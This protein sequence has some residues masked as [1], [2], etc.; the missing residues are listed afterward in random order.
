M[1]IHAPLFGRWAS[2]RTNSFHSSPHS[3]L[4][5]S[6]SWQFSYFCCPSQRSNCTE[7]F[8][9]LLSSPSSVG[10]L[11]QLS[12]C[13]L[14]VNILLSITAFAGNSL[15]L[16]ALHKESCLHPPKPLICWLEHWRFCQYALDAGSILHLVSLIT[17]TAISVDRLL[18]LLSGLRYQLVFTPVASLCGICYHRMIFLYGHLV[19]ALCLVISLASYTKIFRTLRY[20]QAQVRSQQQPSQINALNMA[21]FRKAVY[22]ALWVQ[23]ALVVCYL[24][25]YTVGIVITL[26]KKYSL[27]LIVARRRAVIFLSFNSTLKPFLY[28]WKI[29][30][31]K[32]FDELLCSPSFVGGLQSASVSFAAVN[33]LLSITTFLGNSLILVALNKESPLHPASKFLYR[34]LA[35]TDLL[36]GL[37]A[38][39]LYVTYWMSMMSLNIS[40]I[41]TTAEQ[42]KCIEYGEIKKSGVQCTVGAVCISYLLFTIFYNR[43]FDQPNS[44]RSR[45]KSF[46]ELLCPP[47]LVGGFQQQPSICFLA[48]NILLS[49]TAFAG[50]SP[51]LVAL[52]KKS[53]LHP[54]SELLYRCLATTDL[55]VGLIVQPLNATY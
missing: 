13:L 23:S 14:A 18:A 33:T 6:V 2:T 12:I 43:N 52:H 44:S 11:Q 54:P 48:V 5:H 35:T 9:E 28:C 17:I 19:T 50:N 22:S 8:K 49:I 15:I 38:Q 47:S 4:R 55:L 39:P 37:A 41:T 51:I 30:E 16:V 32:T 21:R 42:T 20:H 31:K 45:T 34:C 7:S 26:T 24:P 29:S 10:G 1:P 36:V 40:N 25:V 3:P 46:E 53:S 27:L